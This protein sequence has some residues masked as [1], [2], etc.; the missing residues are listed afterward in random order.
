MLVVPK[1]KSKKPLIDT[2]TLCSSP[3]PATG[4]GPTQSMLCDSCTAIS[5]GCVLGVTAI[6]LLPSNPS[7]ENLETQRN[8][9]KN[10][11]HV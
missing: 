8:L 1:R 5:V 9:R 6:P 7:T 10:K 3:L 11:N 4:E 2:P